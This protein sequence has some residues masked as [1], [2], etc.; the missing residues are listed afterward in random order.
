MK[1]SQILTKKELLKE[2]ENKNI[3]NSKSNV[4]SVTSKLRMGWNHGK[5]L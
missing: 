5:G 4:I 3:S 1:S 2:L